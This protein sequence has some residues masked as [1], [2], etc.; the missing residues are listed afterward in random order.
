MFYFD[1]GWGTFMNKEMWLNLQ[2]QLN[3]KGPLFRETLQGSRAALEIALKSDTMLREEGAAVTVTGR[4][5]ELF[6]LWVKMEKQPESSELPADVLALRVVLDVA[7]R[8]GESQDEWKSRGVWLC[9]HVLGKVQ[10][11][12]DCRPVTSQVKDYISFPKPNGYQSLHTSI[13]RSN[14]TIEVQIRCPR[15]GISCPHLVGN[16]KLLCFSEPI[17]CIPL[18]RLA[19]S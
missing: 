11:L 3:G 7:H 18:R 5:K 16:I 13:I 14:Q 15:F 17:G 9:Y 12:P 8:L 6:S 1:V 10:Q 4:V 19:I 2:V